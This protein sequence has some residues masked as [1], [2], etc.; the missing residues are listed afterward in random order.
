MLE[1]G[2]GYG[3]VVRV[4]AAGIRGLFVLFLPPDRIRFECTSHRES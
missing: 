3:V 1:R 2:L 4:L